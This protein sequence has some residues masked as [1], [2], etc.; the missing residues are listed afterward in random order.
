[1][2][3]ASRSV[4][5]S[6]ERKVISIVAEKLRTR[7]QDVTSYA[8]LS[9]DLGADS[10][11]S[12]VLIMAIE[13]AFDMDI[14]DEEAEQIVTV[15]QLIEYVEAEKEQLLIGQHSRNKTSRPAEHHK[16]GA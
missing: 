16:P 10:L 12:V 5:G 3:T 1:M 9:A 8:S 6:I 7:E 2:S 15:K 13:D 14:P 11:D 4:Y